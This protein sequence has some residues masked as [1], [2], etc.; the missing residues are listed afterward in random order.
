MKMLG[1]IAALLSYA[2]A[3]SGYYHF[4]RYNTRVS[5]FLPVYDRFDL[6]ALPNK[7]VHYFVSEQANVQLG[8][9]D[10]FP[11]L[12]SQIRAAA[13][14]WNDVETSDLRLAFGGLSAPGQAQASPTIEIIFD[15]TPPGLIALGAPTVRA[16]FNGNFVPILKSVIVLGTDLT[17]RPSWSE[18]FAGTMVH[19][20]GHALGLQH[21]MA[22]SAMSTEV[23]RATSKARPLTADDVAGIS[24]L[25]PRG[26]S[27]TTGAISGRV[28]LGGRGA[29]LAS[30]VA[31]SPNGPAV[32]TMTNPDG[33]YRIEG[34]PARPYLV[35]AHPLPPALRGESGPANIVFPIDAD[36][37]P[38]APSGAF[39]TV[40]F[41]STKEPQQAFAV[42]VA[43]G[44][45]REG[46]DFQVNA[47][48]SV[49]LHSVQTFGFPGS[50]DVKPPHLGAGSPRSY[51]VAAGAGLVANSAPLA[52]LQARVI[53]GAQLLLRPYAPAPASY[54][55]VDIDPRNFSFQSEGPRHMLFSAN[56]EIHVLPNAFYQAD[57]LPPS[58]ASITPGPDRTVT[59][60]GSGLHADTRILFD[61]VA[62]AVRSVDDAAGRMIVAPPPAAQGHRGNVV[63]LASNGQSSLFVQEALPFLYENGETAGAFTLTPPSLPAGSEAVIQID[64]PGANFVE[65]QVSVG[66][67][68]A[69]AP[70]RRLWVASPSRLL[71]NTAVSALAAAS[72]QTVTIASG[73]QLLT[74][75]GGF[76]IT[77]PN[78]RAISLSSNVV[79][80]V[81]G[82]P[83]LY[84]NSPA[85][86]TVTQAPA[87][88]GSLALS[89]W[90]NDRAAQ[91]LGVVGNQVMFSIPAGVP[92]GPAILRFD[93]G[94]DRGLSIAIQIEPPPPQIVAALASVTQAVDAGRPVRAGE[95]VTLHVD[96]LADAGSPIAV[97]RVTVNLGGIEIAP[98]QVLPFGALHQVFFAA[99]ATLP[100]GNSA[101]VT[102]AIDG[103]VSSSI[104]LPIAR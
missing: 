29:N 63:A 51:I 102:V 47:R 1:A 23:T 10:S 84:A 58:L 64:S 75:P 53:G 34:L 22:S 49:P 48:A 37:R 13:K 68:S 56:N 81:S 44:A 88:I 3:A 40:F 31:L 42:N 16:E 38:V 32:G 62:V 35:Y 66:L 30:V 8:S 27:S 70:V 90:I 72:S 65:G 80:A 45:T 7:T 33:T 20:F 11:G 83:V 94:S 79:N 85:I 69:D 36:R 91:I 55:Q 15:E 99:P 104:L 96:G 77:P 26:G 12:V 76:Q 54:L 73:L 93:A 87:P 60:A 82:Q 71:V 59:I 14:V 19:E 2:G 89:A 21:S 18:R 86:A 41:P 17:Q 39:E 67:G 74:L 61:G 24:V 52:G 5:P 25:Y 103:R 57:R 4:V 9:N 101:A 6:S 46:V 28:L 100:A 78:P 43:A 95:L 50:F 98:L 97:S 92:A